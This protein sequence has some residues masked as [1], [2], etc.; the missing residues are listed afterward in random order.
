MLRD[1]ENSFII[2]YRSDAKGRLEYSVLEYLP[3]IPHCQE[4]QT[5]L[6]TAPWK[7][8]ANLSLK[9]KIFPSHILRFLLFFVV[10]FSLLF[11]YS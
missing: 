6:R 7:L 4:S 10:I 5:E 3:L 11:I 9:G 2:I 1:Q 8:S